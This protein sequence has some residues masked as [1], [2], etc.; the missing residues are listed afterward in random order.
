MMRA[1]V[2]TRFGF[3][4]A[5]ALVV[6]AAC[7]GSS[8]TEGPGADAG[9]AG[10]VAPVGASPHTPA[11]GCRAGF[12]ACANVCADTKT[13]TRHCGACGALCPS[14]ASCVDGK[15]TT[16]GTCNFGRIV[17]EGACV[18]ELSSADHC[19]SCFNRCGEGH[20]CVKGA[21]QN[22]QGTGASC[23][24]PVVL[25]PDDDRLGMYFGGTS[26]LHKFPCGP[27]QA[28]PTRWLRWTARK[29]DPT[30][31]LKMRDVPAGDQYV[32]E[33]FTS[34]ACDVPS[35]VGC[36]ASTDKFPEVTFN[37][38]AGRT[39]WFAIGIAAGGARPAV[40]NLDD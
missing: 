24:S 39:Y 1:M 14:D 3:T 20:Y 6:V 27:L 12:T 30:T 40:L 17:C 18:Q 11:T 8:A 33:V 10:P 7:G 2:V 4:L 13:D 26:G 29:S 36:N 19:G 32:L 37:G 21:C 25:P 9:G 38:V 31:E 5:S 35:S 34:E 15:C 28:I 16:G 23:A 22:G